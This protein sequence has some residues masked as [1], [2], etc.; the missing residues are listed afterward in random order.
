IDM[1][2]S[3]VDRWKEVLKHYE[4]VMEALQKP[5]LV[6]MDDFY[7]RELPDLLRGRE[8]GAYITKG[9]LYRLMQWKLRRGKWRPRLL[10]FVSDLR[11]DAVRD[12]SRKAFSSLPDISK[13]VSELT[14]LKGVG[15]AT[16]SAVLAAFS[17]DIVP[18]MSD[19]A[20]EAVIGDSKDYSLK[21][22]TMFVD[23]IQAKAKELST[24]EDPFQPSDVERA[25]WCSSV[26]AK[27]G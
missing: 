14:V 20:M 17:P 26:G 22:Y 3:D 4:A 27:L 6:S 2:T 9:E 19:E 25:L 8:P 16:A 21:R 23:K 10:S 13:A 24:S 5:D 7:R 18:F 12:C 11:D 1:D 15:P